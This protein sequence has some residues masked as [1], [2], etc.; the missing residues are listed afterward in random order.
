[1]K[2]HLLPLRVSGGVSSGFVSLGELG[3]LYPP[4]CLLGKLWFHCEGLAS[5]QLQR[6]VV[7]GALH[8]E[9]EVK[10]ITIPQMLGL[11]LY[12]L[13][14]VMHILPIFFQDFFAAEVGVC[15]CQ[16]LTCCE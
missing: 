9:Q 12:V 4:A 5:R 6:V 16:P 13:L 10:F 15:L 1:M 8:W 11:P 2:I 14:F 3:D 7:T